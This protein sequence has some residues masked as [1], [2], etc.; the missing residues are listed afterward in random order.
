MT[1]LT[2]LLQREL[3]ELI[4]AIELREGFLAKMY[5]RRADLERRLAEAA[6]GDAQS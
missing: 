4:Y 2:A 5:K 3:D 6:E 1:P